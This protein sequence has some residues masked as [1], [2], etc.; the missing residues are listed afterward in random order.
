MSE[1]LAFPAQAR[2]A[3]WVF[4][5][6][7]PEGAL[8]RLVMPPADALREALGLSSLNTDHIEVFQPEVLEGYTL[9]SFLTG[10]NG[11][12]EASVAPDT[13]TLDALEGPVLL[14]F[15]GAL[16]AADTALAPKPPLVFIG[17]YI[18][19]SEATLYEAP[20]FP[21]GATA[22]PLPAETPKPV[23]ARLIGAIVLVVLLLIA[24]LA[25]LTT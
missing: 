9:A 15:S 6:D 17:R 19:K 18:E 3:V 22:P 24:A 11:L 7:L 12:D 4:T 2:R 13:A 25:A 23:S 21:A 1:A 10:A 16:S 8:E 5:A 14:V 20:F